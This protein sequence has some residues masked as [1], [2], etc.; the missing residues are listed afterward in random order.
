M[1]VY[2][3]SWHIR[4]VAILKLL[5][6][7]GKSIRFRLFKKNI[8]TQKSKSFLYNSLLIYYFKQDYKNSI[9]NTADTYRYESAMFRYFYITKIQSFYFNKL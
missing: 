1:K 6:V 9:F 5:S 2:I 3:F 4:I 8:K 7:W